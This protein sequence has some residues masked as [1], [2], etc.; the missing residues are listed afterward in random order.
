MA[1]DVTM[2]DLQSLQG[3][4][5]KKIADLQTQLDKSNKSLEAFR[6]A[7]NVQA[8]SLANGLAKCATTD[9]LNEVIKAL[10]ALSASVEQLKKN[11][12]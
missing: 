10:N 3:H 12:S 1:G 4:C 5:N 7:I 11:A 9:K 8:E 6:T 2:K